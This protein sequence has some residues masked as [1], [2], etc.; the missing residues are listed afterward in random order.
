MKSSFIQINTTA[1]T[2]DYTTS[3]NN[4]NNKKIIY[5]NTLIKNEIDVSEAKAH[6]DKCIIY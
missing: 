2:I 3:I 1:Q 4:H 5:E 6:K